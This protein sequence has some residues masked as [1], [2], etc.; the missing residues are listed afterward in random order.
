MP[1]TMKKNPRPARR[2]KSRAKQNE[3][4]SGSGADKDLW[5]HGY[6]RAAL[7][8][9]MR[10]HRMIEDRAYP[11]CTKM[12]AEFE[13]SVRTLK[14]DIEF[15]KDSL[16]MP[17]E[18]DVPKNGYYFRTP[19]PRFPRVPL[20]E[21]E[22]VGLFV[23]QKT[24]A[25]YHGTSLHPVLDSAFRKMTAQLD[26]NVRYSLGGLDEVLSIRP[27]APGDA[28][29]ETFEILTRAVRERRA[30]RFVYR[31]HGQLNKM[32]KC[33]H[34]YRV[35]YVNNQWTLFAR[36]P[37]A[38]DVARKF[39]LARLSK[40]E[41]TAERFTISGKFDLD[42]ELSGS[43]GVYKG[44]DDF[45]VVVDFDA[46]GADDVRGRRWHSSQELTEI[47]GGRL[48]VKLRLNSL[49]EVE[50]WVLGFGKHAT[51][52]GPE[53]LKQRL[54]GTTEELWQ[55]YGGSMMLHGG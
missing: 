30:V 33:V 11:N 4:F 50:R 38:G 35:A 52:V 15:M 25:Q 37:K 44:N 7:E 6:G 46:W 54:F 41:L 39:I 26:D 12:S 19:Q 17:I 13:V 53:E 24:I 20:T 10:I 49:E 28:E 55:R 23:A 2:A 21:K 9:M 51:V 16:S 32:Q 8:R 34:P 14:R 29:L 27:F 5:A 1:T 42:Q 36:D 22:I 40:P 3:Q 48:R 47:G 18:F 31:K 45:T 43:L